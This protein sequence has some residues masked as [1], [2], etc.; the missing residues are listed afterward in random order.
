MVSDLLYQK[1]Y[2]LR[3]KLSVL[4]SLGFKVLSNRDL[5]YKLNLSPA[6]S[7]NL[8]SLAIVRVL[9][10]L[11]FHAAASSPPIVSCNAHT[12]VEERKD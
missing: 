2:E 7:L 6:S 9:E 10:A 8:A 4:K 3:S 11:R 1:L 5:V 12:A